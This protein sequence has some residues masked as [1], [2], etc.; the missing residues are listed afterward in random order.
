M[1]VAKPLIIAVLGIEVRSD[2][3]L[4]KASVRYCFFIR[5]VVESF[6]NVQISIS[7]NIIDDMLM[8]L[9]LSIKLKDLIDCWNCF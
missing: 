2:E 4:Q 5:L 3:G 6:K 9:L 7:T 8:V 1:L